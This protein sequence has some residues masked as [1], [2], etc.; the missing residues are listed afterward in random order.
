MTTPYVRK[1]WSTQK[2]IG[3]NDFLFRERIL[4]SLSCFYRT[5]SLRALSIGKELMQTVCIHKRKSRSKKASLRL[6]FEYYLSDI[7]SLSLYR[8]RMHRFTTTMVFFLFFFW[9]CRSNRTEP[10]FAS[11]QNHTFKWTEPTLID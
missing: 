1:N 9:L 11:G 6:T 4:S 2:M 7:F 10:H 8:C 5:G 3:E